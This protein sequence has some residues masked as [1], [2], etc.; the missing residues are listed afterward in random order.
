MTTMTAAQADALWAGVDDQRART[1]RL[2]EGLRA[3]QWDHASLCDGWTV[4]HVAAHLTMQQ[5]SFGDLFGFIARH[6][7]MLRSVTLNA[8]IHD[9]AVIR[10]REWSAPQLVDGIR[11]GIGSRRH[12]AFVTPLET[13]TDALV[14]GQDIA[15]PLGLD[16]E[17]RP[18]P[19]ALAATRRWDTRHTWLAW[20]NRR[21]PL[22]DHSFRATDVDWQRGEGSPVVGPIGAILLLLTGRPA[23][24]PRLTGEGA[25]SLRAQLGSHSGPPPRG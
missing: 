9:S 3:D 18:G 15:V 6:P 8:T 2:L 1:T 13:L 17:M 24:L 16:L 7:R 23:A 14:H 4:R 12:N 25:D 5:Q 22:D 21:L 10:A 19:S 11:A 20:V